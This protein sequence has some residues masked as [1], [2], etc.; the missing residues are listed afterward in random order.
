MKVAPASSF[1]IRVDNARDLNNPVVNVV[2][3]DV[4]TVTL[5][6]LCFKTWLEMHNWVGFGKCA[7]LT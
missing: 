1:W 3:F 4:A 2:T 6:S 5:S 7:E